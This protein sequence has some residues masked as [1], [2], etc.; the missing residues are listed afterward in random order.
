ML[1]RITGAQI[2][3]ARALLG[4]SGGLLADKAGVGVATIRR[5]EAHDGIPE[6]NASTI[7]VIQRAFESQ[8]IQFTGDPEANPGVSLD[9]PSR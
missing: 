4:W 3:A 7:S 9:I 1:K 6:A 8:G 2:R 5:I